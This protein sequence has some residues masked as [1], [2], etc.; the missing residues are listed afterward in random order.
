MTSSEEEEEDLG[1][2][3]EPPKLRSKPEEVEDVVGK[4]AC[5]APVGEFAEVGVSK[6][7]CA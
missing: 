4:R 3:E 6:C 5:R 1:M 2:M 7:C